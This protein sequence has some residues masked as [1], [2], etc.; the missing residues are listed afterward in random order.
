MLFEVTHTIE[1]SYSQPVFLEP[2]TVRLRPRCDS[3]QK[4][5]DFH[6]VVE[7]TPAGLTPCNDLDG[8]LTDYVWFEGL[9]DL[10]NITASFSLETLRLDPFD[11]ILEPSAVVLPMAYSPELSAALTAHRARA[12]SGGEVAHFAEEVAREIDW[13]T[14]PFLGALTSRIHQT[15]EGII[16]PVNDPWPASETLAKRQG[17]CRDTAVLL[18]D[19]CRSVGIAARFVSGYQEGVLNQTER[20]LHA[21]V[22]VYLPGAGWRGYD[23]TLG[24]AVS[25]RHIAVA[26]GPTPRA[27]APTSGAFRGTDATSTM[28]TDIRM[29][30]TG[31]D[32]NGSDEATQVSSDPR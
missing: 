14:V 20:E 21:W 13:E 4:V 19:A 16:R 32:S 17:S 6:L 29:N 11:F 9:Q 1:F 10:L 8:N 31:S 12:D 24:L 30:I 25:D 23:P 22:E 15:C 5:L 26:A 7:P 28:R 3:Q 2:H 27:T 18:M